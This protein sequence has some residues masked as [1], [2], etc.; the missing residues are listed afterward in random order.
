[1]P[2]LCADVDI[3]VYWW[4]AEADRCLLVGVFKH[5][6]LHVLGLTLGT[7]TIRTELTECHFDSRIICSCQFQRFKRVIIM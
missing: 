7:I 1:M 4:D 6:N 3:P 5:G 2:I